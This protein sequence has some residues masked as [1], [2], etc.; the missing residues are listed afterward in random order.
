MQ[1]EQEQY[2]EKLVK[3][4]QNQCN[5]YLQERVSL[6][7][8]LDLVLAEIE[9]LETKIKELDPEIDEALDVNENTNT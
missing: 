4:Y 9:R 7:A 5:Q 3:V 1:I 6:Q 2:L 8:Q